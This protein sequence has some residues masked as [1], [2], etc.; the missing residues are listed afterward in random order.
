MFIYFWCCV[1]CACKAAASKTLIVPPDIGSTFAESS[2]IPRDNS[3]PNWN[4]RLSAWTATDCGKACMP[5]DGQNLCQQ[6]FPPWRA[7]CILCS[8]WTEGHWTSNTATTVMV[9]LYTWSLSQ[10]SDRPAREQ[11]T[12]KRG[13]MMESRPWPHNLRGPAG[14]NICRTPK[15]ITLIQGSHLL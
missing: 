8:I 1:Q 9:N 11:I 13:V 3:R 5:L 6:G 14:R 2:W 4:P 7:Q 15:P 10:A 12:V